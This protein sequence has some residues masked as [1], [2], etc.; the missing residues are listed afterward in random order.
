MPLPAHSTAVKGPT[1]PSLYM[2]QI[3]LR[4]I[5]L[6]SCDRE[7]AGILNPVIETPDVTCHVSD[8]HAHQSLNLTGGC[9]R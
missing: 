6:E 5:E 1:G 3:S 8:S 9:R 7:P 4:S 2:E